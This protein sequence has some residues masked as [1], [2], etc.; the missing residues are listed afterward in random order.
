MTNDCLAFLPCGSPLSFHT[1]LLGELSHLGGGLDRTLSSAS[2]M[3][4]PLGL[5]ALVLM[6]LMWLLVP[7]DSG[8]ST[9]GA[10]RMGTS[11][12]PPATLSPNS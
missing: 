2:S 5:V 12:Q 6:W 11:G 3:C 1:A 10:G 4:L 8:D 9:G 7:E